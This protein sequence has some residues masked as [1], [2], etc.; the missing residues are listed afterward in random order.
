[1]TTVPDQAE[2]VLIIQNFL[3]IESSGSTFSGKTGNQFALSPPIQ[4]SHIPFPPRERYFFKT[5][6]SAEGFVCPS[7]FVL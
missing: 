4:G 6:F 1:M 3:P 2:T 5:S 7:G